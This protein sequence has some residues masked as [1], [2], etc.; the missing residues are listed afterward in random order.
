MSGISKELRTE[1]LLDEIRAAGVEELYEQCLANGSTMEFAAMCALRQPPG[2]RNT[3][4]A[5]CQGAERQ[6]RMMAPVNRKIIYERAQKAGISTQGKWYKGSL[7]NGDPAN[8]AAWVSSAD[9]VVA[10]CK[11]KGYS[12]EGVINYTAPDIERA[13]PKSV[14]LAPDLVNEGVRMML[15]GDPALAEK[16]KKNPKILVEVKERV[17]EKHGKR[18][19]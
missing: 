19:K 5:F 14:R 6:T 12:M 1:M 13:P 11:A 2:S 16:V 10:V 17:I 15:Q 8:P 3:D 18:K 7:G 9:D 4:R